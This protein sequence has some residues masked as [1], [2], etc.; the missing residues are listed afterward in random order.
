MRKLLLAGVV[1]LAGCTGGET[2]APSPSPATSPAPVSTAAPLRLAPQP[3]WSGTL[4]DKGLPYRGVMRVSLVG[5][6]LLI[7]ADGRE[8]AY[9]LADAR[10]G[11]LRWSVKHAAARNTARSILTGDPDGDWTLVANYASK[12]GDETT[13]GILGYSGTDG[14]VRWQIPLARHRDA[15]TEKFEV[16]LGAADGDTFWAAVDTGVGKEITETRMEAWDVASRRKLWTVDG[17][18]P[19]AVAGDIVLGTRPVV[20]H[21]LAKRGVG[22]VS[23]HDRRTGKKIWDLNGRSEHSDVGFAGNGL[24]VAPLWDTSFALPGQDGTAILEL[25]TGAELGREEVAITDCKVYGDRPICWMYG[26]QFTFAEI[27]P[28]GTRTPVPGGKQCDRFLPWRELYV[29]SHSGDG[30][31]S[32]PVDRTGALAGPAI[33]GDVHATSD[34]LVV[35]ATGPVTGERTFAVHETVS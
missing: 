21:A 2:P 11:E 10:T 22:F 34:R 6:G 5:D 26:P 19:V 12:K 29:C 20:P 18:Q 27:A 7:A 31:S 1:L 13:Q 24:I 23:A 3:L 32:Q 28:D 35:V 14:T 8:S 4:R 9:G 25:A 15:D 16:R 33:P 30:E 17:A